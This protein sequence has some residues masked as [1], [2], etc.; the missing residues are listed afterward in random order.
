MR[1]KK[2]I[3]GIL[4]ISFFIGMIVISMG[5]T[6]ISK[7]KIEN[8]ARKAHSISDE[9][10]VVKC[11]NDDLGVLLFYSKDLSDHTFSI[12][13]NRSRLFSRYSFISGGALPAI[14]EEILN[15]NDIDK[16]NIFL[17]LNKVKVSR[18]EICIDDNLKEISIDNDKPFVII[19]PHSAKEIK[20]YDSNNNIIPYIK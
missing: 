17:S 5:N 19:I 4:S 10:E 1:L 18:M 13:I 11:I 9:W 20:F 16:G 3:I 7:N 12:Y 14:N 15:I 2:Y 6:E 8:K